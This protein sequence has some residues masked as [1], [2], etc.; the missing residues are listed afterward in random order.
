MRENALIRVLS[1]PHSELNFCP[2]GGHL[3]LVNPILRPSPL[4]LPALPADRGAVSPSLPAFSPS[5]SRLSPVLS[6][7]SFDLAADVLTATLSFPF[8]AT[9]HLTF[10]H[11]SSSTP[12]SS[13]VTSHSVTSSLLLPLELTECRTGPICQLPQNQWLAMIDP[14]PSLTPSLHHDTSL[15]NV[16]ELCLSKQ[17]EYLYSFKCCLNFEWIFF[18]LV[19]VTSSTAPDFTNLS[20]N[21]M[22][23][24]LFC[25]VA[26]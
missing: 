24:G 8:S 19:P 12:R 25:H 13:Y 14:D 26:F 2:P 7:S 4:S 9:I 21:S 18:S 11:H 1:L 6:D 3:L 5:P 17:I 20:P 22:K 15:P 16:S 10:P 23:Q